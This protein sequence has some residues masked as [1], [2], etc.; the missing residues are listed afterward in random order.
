MSSSLQNKVA[1]A[2]LYF[3][4]KLIM[5]KWAKRFFLDN[6]TNLAI[7]ENECAISTQFPT[8]QTRNPAAG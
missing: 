5:Q 2:V 7:P 6:E 3:D 8:N 4:I 1:F